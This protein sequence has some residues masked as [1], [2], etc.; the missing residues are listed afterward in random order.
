MERED[1]IALRAPFGGSG[2]RMVSQTPTTAITRATT[3][4]GLNR[5]E[6]RIAASIALS[7]GVKKNK[8]L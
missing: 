1:A 8:L 7:A 2:V 3:A 5:S 4:S 6:N